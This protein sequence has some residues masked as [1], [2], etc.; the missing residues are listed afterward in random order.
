MRSTA[1]DS[2]IGPLSPTYLDTVLR[3][4]DAKPVFDFLKP[5][6]GTLSGS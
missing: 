4:Y 3:C 1:G 2:E 5:V 6:A